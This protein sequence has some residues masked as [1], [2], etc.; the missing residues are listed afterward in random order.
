[1]PKIKQPANFMS[2]QQSPAEQIFHAAAGL[3][4]SAVSN[5][6]TVARKVR[7]SQDAHI[8]KA[9]GNLKKYGKGYY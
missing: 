1:M 5:I 9:K 7:A 3:A 4:S 6:K 2:P 8:E